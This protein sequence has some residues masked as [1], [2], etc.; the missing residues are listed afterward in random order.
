M[1]MMIPPEITTFGRIVSIFRRIDFHPA[2][3]IAPVLLSIIAATFEGAGMGLLIPMLQGFLTMDFSFTKEV[4]VL[5]I[6]VSYLPDSVLEADRWLFVSLIGLF[7]VVMLLKNVLKYLALISI[8]YLGIR[9][10]HHLRKLL[11]S[12]YL[13]FGKLYFDSSHVGHHTA[14]MSEFAQQSLKPLQGVGRFMNSMFSLLAYLVMMT[15]ISWKLT[16]FALPLLFVL[17]VAV[18][19]LVAI[20]RRLS[21]FT[22]DAVRNLSQKTIEMLS[23]IPLVKACN[24]E[25]KE[26]EHYTKISNQRAKLD[27][28]KVATQSL[29]LPLQ[30]VLTLCAILLLFSAMLYLRAYGGGSEASALLVYFLLVNNAATKFGAI[31]SFRSGLASTIAPVEEVERVLDDRGKC[32]VPS[33]SKTFEGLRGGIEFKNLRFTFPDG[34]TVFEDLSFNIRPEKMTAIVGP[35]GAGKTTIINLLLRFYDCPPGTVFVDSEDIRNFKTSS[36]R[37]H[38][39]LVSQETLLLH[40]TLK[41]NISYGLDD[42][43]DKDVDE[44][45]SQARLTEF[46]KELPEGLSTLIGDRGVKLSGGEKQRVAIARALLKGAGI[47]I[48]DEATSSLDS[49]TE[50]LI[51]E[52]IDEA[53]EGRT[54]IVIAH[55]L[56]T[57][58]HADHIV[59]I[60][61][62]CVAEEGS[63]DD[64]V[65][66]RGLFAKM[67]EDQKF[68]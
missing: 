30:E 21:R 43:S 8:S 33:G 37:D 25:I 38:M 39:S 18:R 49:T 61:D 50:K 66:A 12:R 48:L 9:A 53:V 14:V 60:N 16:L 42:V 46:I 68:S 44:A 54:S 56:S 26:K 28:H 59:V 5:G 27:F 32:F 13:S 35:T 2:F 65:N 41:N 11:F 15:L 17:H 29:I 62:G 24:M 57:I 52:A 36:L 31:T 64:L 40:D 51:Q 4:P 67:W 55:R 63:L 22:V 58:K 6:V 45:V 10:T 34:K 1:R 20:L 3:L 47:L 23:I 7:V 19:R